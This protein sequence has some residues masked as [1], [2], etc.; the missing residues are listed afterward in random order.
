M[1]EFGPIITSVK[2]PIHRD[3]MTPVQMTRLSQITGRD[4]RVI[5]AYLGVIERNQS[6]LR[7]GRRTRLD[8]GTLDEL[9]LTTRQCKNNRT[10]VPHDFKARFPRMSTNEFGQCRDTAIAMWTS[11][12]ELGGARPLTS[13]NY[14]PRKIPRCVFPNCF[15]L[16]RDSSTSKYT[17]E[18]RDSLDSTRKGSRQHDKLCIPL[19]VSDYHETRLGEGEVKSVRVVKDS[20][21][22]W[23]AVFSVNLEPEPQDSR[24][25]QPA[26]LAIDLGIKKAATTV[27]LTQN[28]IKEVRYWKGTEKLQHMAAYDAAVG[29]LQRAKTQ[30]SD[31]NNVPPSLTEKLS[32]LRHKRANISR[33]YDR[34]LVKDISQY[35]LELNKTYNLYVA[36]GRLSGIRNRARKGNF[37]GPRFRGMIHRWS[38]ARVSD[39]FEHKLATLGLSTRR[40][41][42][43]AETWTS[44]VCH[45]CGH[46]GY[47]PKQSLFIC[48]T[49]G[50]HT[51]ADLNAAVNIGRRLIM[52]I[53][54][55]RDETKGLGMSLP[56][57]RKAA[58]KAP[59]GR[60]PKGKSLPSQ[61][62]PASFKGGPVAADRAQMHL[63]MPECGEDP[64]MEKT[65][66]R[67]SAPGS[68]GDSGTNQQQKETTHRE[69]NKVPEISGKAHAQAL[70]QLPL[71]DWRQPS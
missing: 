19:S 15:S 18:L 65:V 1:K 13:K 52:L 27:L 32:K 43:V 59:R 24:G 57:W 20:L 46:V 70:G 42:R 28:G 69:R 60:N 25:K 41:R 44:R 64:A 17:L 10:S 53:P 63:I 67:P 35:A 33:E 2:I 50:L 58:P 55:L 47:R 14:K 31:H 36:I 12:L 56:P 62:S 23:W 7:T 30:P 6:Q 49:C 66:E 29:A 34:K 21:H 4:T 68:T 11:Y 16:V 51:N 48:G 61:R 5:K 54:A 3:D 38:F 22:K 39:S 71:S 37:Q 9:T 26:V 8:R 45:R 40:F